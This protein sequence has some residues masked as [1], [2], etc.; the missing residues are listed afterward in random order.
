M[1][2]IPD[3]LIERIIT[4]AEQQAEA[5]GSLVEIQRQNAVRLESIHGSSAAQVGA[6]QLIVEAIDRADKR[7]DE[8]RETA[9]AEVKS[10]VSLETSRSERAWKLIVLIVTIILATANVIG[11]LLARLVLADK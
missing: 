9:V 3:H 11:P 5:T 2:D 6:L 10:H 4:T 8:R 7:A 1:T